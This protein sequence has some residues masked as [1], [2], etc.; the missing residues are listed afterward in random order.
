MKLVHVEIGDSGLPIRIFRDKS[1]R[2]LPEDR[3]GLM[4]KEEAVG[5]IRDQVYER[6]SRDSPAGGGIAECENCGRRITWK[7]FEMNE[8][9]P[10]G[11]GG[12]KTGGEVSLENCEAL[13]HDCHQG[14]PDSA[15]GDRRWHTSKLTEGQNGN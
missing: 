2:L 3:V 1:W 8:R 7:T 15:H 12:G 4:T 5:S 10:K 13:C 6:A 9:R 14:S 11:A